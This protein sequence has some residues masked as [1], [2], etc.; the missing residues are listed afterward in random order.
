MKN[1]KNDIT[2][3]D[4]DTTV[5]GDLPTAEEADRM[6][7]AAA[8]P[9]CGSFDAQAVTNRVLAELRSSAP[10]E[11]PA[12][13]PRRSRRVLRIMLVA[14][15]AAV[16][17]FGTLVAVAKIFYDTR[18]TQLLGLEEPPQKL[19]SSYFRIDTSY[20]RWNGITM[21]VID[22][23]GDAGTQWIEFQT[24]CKLEDGTPDGWFTKHPANLPQT[25]V[26]SDFKFFEFIDDNTFS[27][28]DS[29]D[30]YYRHIANSREAVSDSIVCL[31]PFCRDGYLWYLLEISVSKK[32][33]LARGFAHLVLDVNPG[34]SDQTLFEFN[35][36]NNY[37]TD[38]TKTIAASA[39]IEKSPDTTIDDVEITEVTLSATS[40]IV[41]CLSFHEDFHLD[42]ITLEDGTV[43]YTCGPEDN[44]RF[45]SNAPVFGSIYPSDWDGWQRAD[46]VGIHNSKTYSLLPG[47][48]FLTPSTTLIPAEKI[49]AIT[50]NGIRINLR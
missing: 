49:A 24:N 44:P 38:T 20:Q 28:A 37:P 18:L 9:E 39:M 30:L 46:S 26:L 8:E 14:A 50:V 6:D 5:F 3:I 19:E 11:A 29:I 31:A 47:R 42:S 13:T 1:S 17:L 45:A 12:T 4:N 32:I 21:T 27:D 48:S 2:S 22:A 40:L 10:A 43:L 15:C 34:T 23:I 16:L 33:N 25:I 7:A 36:V 41:H 35:W